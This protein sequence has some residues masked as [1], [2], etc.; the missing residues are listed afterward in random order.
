MTPIPESPAGV[1]RKQRAPTLYV[2]IGIKLLKGLLAQLGIVGKAVLVEHEP[3]DALVLSGRNL[4][5]VRVVADSHLTAYD[6]MDCKHLLLTPEALGKLAERLTRAP[7]IAID[8]V[9]ELGRASFK[10]P[11]FVEE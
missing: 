1:P 9:G 10:L 5:G 2:I 4:P 11:V 6:V 3:A 8:S 7:D